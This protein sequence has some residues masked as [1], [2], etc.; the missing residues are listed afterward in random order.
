MNIDEMTARMKEGRG[1]IAALDQSGGSTPK[2]LKAYGI[3]DGAWSSDDEMFALIHAMRERIIDRLREAARLRLSA[4]AITDHDGFYGAV[5]LAEAASVYRDA[6][7]GPLVKTVFGAELSLGLSAPQNG[8]ADPEGD[9]LLV[10]ARG[11]RG[12]HSLAA[13][14]TQGQLASDAEKG[15]PV[16]QLD[17][18]SDRAGGDWMVL[19]GCRKGAVRRALAS[20][21]GVALAARDLEDLVGAL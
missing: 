1:F 9:H 3:E 6:A 16:Y 8:V 19:S 10:L 2:A 15:R 7:G 18:L 13:A 14:I 12:Y 17:A 4:L 5:Q 11:M 20:E 21:G